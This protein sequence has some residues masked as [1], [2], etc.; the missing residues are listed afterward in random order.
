MG[1]LGWKRHTGAGHDIMSESGVRGLEIA[2]G[3]IC[4]LATSIVMRIAGLGFS[5]RIAHTAWAALQLARAVAFV[6]FIYFALRSLGS[7]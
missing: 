7:G 3:L 5:S 1:R 6:Y 4:P 2:D